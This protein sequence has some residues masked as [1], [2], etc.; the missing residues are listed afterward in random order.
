MT[1]FPFLYLI[2]DP[3]LFNETDPE[4][5]HTFF[6][7]VSEAIDGGVRMIQYRDKKGQRQ[8]MYE[9]AKHLREM[10][11]CRDISLIINDEVDLALAVKADG[12]H[13]GQDD[14][15]IWVARKLLGTKAM[16][17]LSTHNLEQAIRA[18]SEAVD[19]IGVGPIFKTQTKELSGPPLGINGLVSIREKAALPI[20]AI[21]GIQFRHLPGVM[22]AGVAGV[23][24]A[25]ALSRSTRERCE[26]WLN[27]LTACTT[28]RK[29]LSHERG[30]GYEKSV[31]EGD[32]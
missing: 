9:T 21:G 16:V 2:A 6:R 13:L 10:T 20:Y 8:Q 7:F 32:S 31:T 28:K 26:Q 12:V 23:A 4:T 18:A 30:M 14:L 19:Y 1:A 29:K 24:V 11:L 25:S 22:S 15:P 27:K 3:H 17:G 5:R